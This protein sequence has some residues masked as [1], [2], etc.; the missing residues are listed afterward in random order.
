MSDYGFRLTRDGCGK[1]SEPE[2]I[3]RS[4]SLDEMRAEMKKKV[5]DEIEQLVKD[6]T[7]AVSIVDEGRDVV[8]IREKGDNRLVSWYEI[9]EFEQR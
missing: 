1:Y 2:T 6:G 9:E 3:A 7:D 8:E 5:S 4:W